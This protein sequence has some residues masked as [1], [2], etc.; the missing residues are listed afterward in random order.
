MNYYKF[1]GLLFGTSLNLP[2]L[3]VNEVKSN[4]IQLIKVEADLIEKIVN[5][6]EQNFYITKDWFYFKKF[7]TLCYYNHKENKLLYATEDLK[8]FILLLTGYILKLLSIYFNFV[9][10]HSAVISYK[11]KNIIILGN[12]GSGKSSIICNF[13]FLDDVY[14]ITDDIFPIYA[15]KEDNFYGSYPYIKLWENDLKN[16]WHGRKYFQVHPRIKKYFVEFKDKFICKINE[17]N[18]CIILKFSKNDESYINFLKGKE[19]FL[20]LLDFVYMKKLIGIKENEYLILADF[21][22]KIPIYEFSRPLNY[23]SYMSFSF[24]RDFFRSVL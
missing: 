22:N 6:K 5:I 14:L 2:F 10:L 21:I 1:C 17:I 8:L 12:K 18:L 20:K 11:G 19:K 16:Y 7:G 15:G 24:L 13:L 9:L 4:F 23:N 3:K